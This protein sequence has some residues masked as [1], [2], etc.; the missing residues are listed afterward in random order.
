MRRRSVAWMVVVRVVAV[1]V[2]T[3]QVS[4][5]A[6][7]SSGAFVSGF[8]RSRTRGRAS[9]DR[10]TERGSPS[11]EP[12]ATSSGRWRR[13]RGDHHMQVAGPVHAL[14]AI[15]LDV[16]R[17]GR[18]ADPG[19][20]P[21]RVERGDARRGRPRRPGPARTTH[22][23]WSG[24]RLSARRP[25]SSPPS[26]TIV[27]VSA[28]ATAHPVT[29][30]SIRSSSALDSGGSSAMAS[31][32]DGSQSRGTPAGTTI[33]RAASPP[34]T[35]SIAGAIPSAST[36]RHLRAIVRD[37]L[38][39]QR[40]ERGRPRRHPPR[41]AV[42]ARHVGD[43]RVVRE[44]LPDG[45]EDRVAS[46]GHRSALAATSDGTSAAPVRGGRAPGTRRRPARAAA[47]GRS[48]RRGR[49]P[50]TRLP[51]PARRH[52]AAR[53]PRT[54]PRGCRSSPT[55]ARTAGRASR[56]AGRP[57]PAGARAPPGCRSSTGHTS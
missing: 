23:W 7:G 31:I 43:D 11:V 1:G 21:A 26:S 38:R 33:R 20:R 39:E 4:Q 55:P 5:L 22:T 9:A 41:P 44:R 24:T 15:E 17:R 47:G 45:G 14:H 29:T 56:A 28:I 46:R 34:S 18:A 49:R 19:Q 52:R 32:P 27:P 40:D 37:P 3:A 57:S 36:N 42:V 13:V 25:W 35:A 54:P 2:C 10:G 51:R 30:A 53:R 16:A 6:P 12:P 48:A 50:S 8:P